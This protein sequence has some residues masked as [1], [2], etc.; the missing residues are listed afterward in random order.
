MTLEHPLKPTYL[1][2]TSRLRQHRSPAFLP[3]AWCTEQERGSASARP[4]WTSH[5]YSHQ[6][7]R[8]PRNRKAGF[9]EIYRCRIC[10][11]AIVW[12]CSDTLW[13]RVDAEKPP[14]HKKQP[15]LTKAEPLVPKPKDP[16]ADA[17]PANGKILG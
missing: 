2:R 5:S 7:P 13:S 17:K 14:S 9:D 16:F 8:D 12:G 10:G 4:V 1:R 6:Q 3:C 11:N 15:D